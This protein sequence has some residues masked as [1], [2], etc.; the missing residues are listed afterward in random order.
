MKSSTSKS[1]IDNFLCK[2]WKLP[3]VVTVTASQ[4]RAW[5]FIL[6]NVKFRLR[7]IDMKTIKA[8]N[9]CFS[10]YSKGDLICHYVILILIWFR[11]FLVRVV[12]W[13]MVYDIQT[14]IEIFDTKISFKVVTIATHWRLEIVFIS[15]LSTKVKCKVNKWTDEKLKRDAF[16]TKIWL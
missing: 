16:M 10:L 6:S 3:M 12:A 13:Y 2:F 11:Q 1:T 4:K 7:F 15:L 14:K 5:N 9:Y 8:G